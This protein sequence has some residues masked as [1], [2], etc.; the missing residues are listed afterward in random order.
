MGACN[1]STQEC[2]G[3]NQEF[4]QSQ[5]I[6]LH[7]EGAK[8]VIIKEI[9]LKPTK[10]ES[11]DIPDERTFFEKALD[12]REVRGPYNFDV[13]PI[14]VTVNQLQSAA[15]VP[16]TKQETEKAK[17]SSLANFKN[18]NE[19]KDQ[20]RQSVSVTPANKIRMMLKAS[21]W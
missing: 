20:K 21:A 11:I 9:P 10:R 16:N 13:R 1:S 4:I 18:V 2:F 12:E 15:V 7:K 19:Q 8:Q 6:S 3:S 14:S 17:H 5:E